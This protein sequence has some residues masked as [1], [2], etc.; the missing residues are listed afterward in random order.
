[1]QGT[2][3]ALHDMI[4]QEWAVRSSSLQRLARNAAYSGAKARGSS[5]QNAVDDVDSVETEKTT[6][7]QPMRLM[8]KLDIAAIGD[9]ELVLMMLLKCADL[10]HTAVQ[11]DV[12]LCWVA[13]LQEE[14]CHHISVSLLMRLFCPGSHEL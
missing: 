7:H 3:L 8:N 5:T 13:R 9:R 1:M 4:M 14:V 11:T 12:H 10:S 6:G 2:D